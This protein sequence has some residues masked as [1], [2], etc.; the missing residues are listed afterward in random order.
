VGLHKQKKKEKKV[1]GSLIPKQVEQLEFN[2]NM[3]ERER[4]RERTNTKV[5]EL[6]NNM[7]H[8]PLR[9]KKVI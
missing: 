3:R 4:E 8:H 7:H 1:G 9:S 6:E 5:I 2:K